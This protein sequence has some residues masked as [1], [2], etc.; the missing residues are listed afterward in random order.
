M[1]DAFSSR[2]PLCTSL[3]NAIWPLY[4]MSAGP[5]QVWV[6]GSRMRPRPQPTSSLADGETVGVTGALP[7]VVE[8]EV[9][10][11]AGLV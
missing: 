11:N 4:L 8:V 7:V 10:W 5:R 3:E 2:E 9:V 1:F 6:C